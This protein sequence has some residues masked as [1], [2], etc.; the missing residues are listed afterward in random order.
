MMKFILLFLFIT[1]ILSQ[2][3]EQSE[4]ARRLYRCINTTSGQVAGHPSPKQPD[5]YE[6]LGIP[7]AQP[8]IGDL[9]FAPPQPFI[10]NE[11]IN[12][13]NFVSL[14]SLVYPFNN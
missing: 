9:R 12:G 8:P 10:G 2:C 1:T 7:F 4:A 13:T 14:L 6:Y 11:S 5:V 3:P